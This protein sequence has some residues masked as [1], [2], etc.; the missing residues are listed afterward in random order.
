M[1]Q[2]RGYVLA[3]VCL[4]VCLSVCQ[5]LHVNT[6]HYNFFLRPRVVGNSGKQTFPVRRLQTISSP[7]NVPVT[8]SWLSSIAVT[9]TAAASVSTLGPVTSCSLRSNMM[10]LALPSNEF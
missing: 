7:A 8:A 1:L 3:R 10:K 2:Q 6:T 4:S 9:S 5:Q